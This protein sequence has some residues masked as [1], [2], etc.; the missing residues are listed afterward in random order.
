MTPQES[1]TLGGQQAPS[2]TRLRLRAPNPW[3]CPIFTGSPKPINI[4]TRMLHTKN[5]ASTR[6]PL[7]YIVMLLTYKGSQQRT[8]YNSLSPAP[9]RAHASAPTRCVR[10]AGVGHPGKSCRPA[11]RGCLWQEPHY[12]CSISPPE[13]TGSLKAFLN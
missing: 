3:P 5:P 4:P 13:P 7:L 10:S 6:M 8:G 9:R 11:G 12:I 1:K 2:A